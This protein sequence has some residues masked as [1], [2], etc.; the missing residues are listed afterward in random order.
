MKRI[1]T[2]LGVLLLIL[3]PL[4]LC[5]ENVTIGGIR[6][7]LRITNNTATVIPS[8]S[9]TEAGFPFAN[10]YS[11]NI[12]IPSKVTYK[13]QDYTVT[14]IGKRAF[15]YCDN[16]NSVSLPVT[17]TTIDEEAFYYCRSLFSVGDISNVTHIGKNA[18]YYCTG[19]ASIVLGD[20]ITKIEDYTFFNC[21]ALTSVTI[22][23]GVT[24]IEDYAFSKCES[25]G[26][27]DI[28]NSVIKIDSRAFAYC[29]NLT[30]INFGSNL[31]S[32]GQRAFAYCYNL[33]S[34]TLP[35]SVESIGGWAFNGCYILN[36]VIALGKTPASIENDYTFPL[37]R[38]MK[39]YVPYG[40]T[41]NYDMVEYWEDFGQIIE[42][43]PVELSSVTVTVSEYGVATF[44]SEYGLDFTNI[45]G[46]TARIA[47]DYDGNTGMIVLEAVGEVPALTGL[48]LTGEPGTYEIPVVET[49]VTYN[50]MFVGTTTDIMLSPTDGEYTNFILYADKKNGA[51]FRPLSTTGPLKAHRAYLQIPTDKLVPSTN[52]NIVVDE[53]GQTGMSLILSSSPKDEGNDSYYTL[54]GRRLSAA[55]TQKGMYIH[56]GKKMVVN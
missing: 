52:L 44:C 4:T 33:Q 8:G 11:G 18:F 23:N 15:Y 31:K 26:S 16:L 32:I 2:I 48:F 10:T 28:P 25:L 49:N 56:N 46:L 12:T 53:G 38:N 30:S 35:A 17:V 6:Y 42:M 50:N 43:S 51:S 36:E 47:T 19:L 24:I 3:A 39:L 13:G 22:G 29:A 27:I 1:T 54:D 40:C 41:D 21:S 55:P 34:I 45:N 20:E 9:Y 7:D 14:T 5:A 37:R